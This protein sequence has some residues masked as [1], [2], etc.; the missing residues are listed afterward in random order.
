MILERKPGRRRRGRQG[1][2]EKVEELHEVR[3][4]SILDIISTSF[5]NQGMEVR[6]SGKVYRHMTLQEHFELDQVRRFETNLW[7]ST[8]KS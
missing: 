7:S 3:N 6:S 5:Q 8:L 2:L 1:F 4:A